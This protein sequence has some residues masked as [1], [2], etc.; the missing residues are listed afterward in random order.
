MDDGATVV[1]AVEL[2][3]AGTLVAVVRD[4]GDGTGEG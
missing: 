3:G 2:G 4:I 1:F